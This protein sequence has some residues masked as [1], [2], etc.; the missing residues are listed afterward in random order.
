MYKVSSTTKVTESD[1][2]AAMEQAIADGVDIMSL[3]LGFEPKP[4]FKELVGIASVSSVEKGV[5]VVCAVENFNSANTTLNGAP[6]IT[7]GGAGIL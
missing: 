2:L 4:L 6:W 3:S 7:S 5:A 1:M